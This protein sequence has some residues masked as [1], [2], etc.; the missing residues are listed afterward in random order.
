MSGG[1]IRD[2]IIREAGK[3]TGREVLD[4]LHPCH[5]PL[6][7]KVGLVE[8]EGYRLLV[9]IW[10]TMDAVITMTELVDYSNVPKQ[11]SR[12]LQEEGMDSKQSEV[13]L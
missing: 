12:K 6:P 8:F 3:W 2:L 7:D 4:W 10:S 1:Y 11:Q 13:E 9:A 5:G